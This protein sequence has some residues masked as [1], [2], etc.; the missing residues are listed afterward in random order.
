[1]CVRYCQDIS[2]FG[3]YHLKSELQT[4]QAPIHEALFADD[5]TKLAHTDRNIQLIRKSFANASK[6]FGLNISLSERKVLYQAALNATCVVLIL[7]THVI[8][9]D[10]IIMLL[11][12]CML[13]VNPGRFTHWKPIYVYGSNILYMCMQ[14]IL[15]YGSLYIAMYGMF[16]L[17]HTPCYYIKRKRISFG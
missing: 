11:C 14:I 4:F 2:I 1:M 10:S 3:L 5:C 13:L 7:Y 9:T 6:P 16:I 12:H 8:Y 17:L 15:D